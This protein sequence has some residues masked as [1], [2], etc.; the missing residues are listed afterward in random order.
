MSFPQYFE[1]IKKVGVKV[2]DTP[3]INL[4]SA[5]LSVPP[6]FAFPQKGYTHQFRQK[7][8]FLFW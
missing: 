3:K 7:K 8:I 2:N 6:L 1:K 4:D 5:A